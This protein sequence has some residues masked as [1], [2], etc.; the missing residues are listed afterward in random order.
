M[1]EGRELN[2]RGW[3]TLPQLVTTDEVLEI[4]RC[5][6]ALFLLPD[7]HRYVGDKPAAGTRHLSGLEQR[8]PLVADIIVR[9]PLLVAVRAL[10][11]PDALLTQA[12]LRS[13]RPGFGRQLLHADDVPKLDA[14]PDTVATAVVALVDVTPVNGGTRII[15]GSHRRPDLQLRSGRLKNHQDELV[16]TGDA[17]TAFVISGHLLHAGGENNSN[18]ER[19]VLQLC[20]RAA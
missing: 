2:E 1:T 4:R 16:L 3:T 13:P 19:P 12:S 14:T 10:I 20:W 15:P 7:E 6:E 17:G 8:I 5:C 11:G 9:P 18:D